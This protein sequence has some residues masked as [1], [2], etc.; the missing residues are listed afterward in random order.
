MKEIAFLN[1][2]FTELAEASISVNDRGYLFG[3][4]VYEVIRGYSGRLWAF[5]RHW[6]RLARSLAELRIEGVDLEALEKIARECVRR[7]GTPE[8]L[9]YVQITRGIAPRSHQWEPN[10]VPSILVTVRE[11][12]RPSE[13]ARRE[14][15]ACITTLDTRWKRCDI[16]SLNLLPNVLA[17]QEAHQAG[18]FE[19]IFRDD[20]GII[21]EGSSTSVGMVTAGALVLH[22]SGARVLP[23]ISRD[24]VCELAH[25]RGIEVRQEAFDYAALLAADEVLLAGTT[26][27]V[28]G[29]VKIDGQPIGGGRLGPVAGYLIDAFGEAVRSGADAP[30]C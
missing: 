26:T 5:E 2:D 1:G 22:P 18:A 21:T 12:R 3:D 9:L 19:A 13:T 29:V 28:V 4:G 20:D 17:K 15:V 30:R 14:G 25:E 27:E 11:A 10:L 24:L 8:P 7:A 23:S 6:R 16:K